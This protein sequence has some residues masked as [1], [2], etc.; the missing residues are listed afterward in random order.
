VG[1]GDWCLLCDLADKYGCLSWIGMVGL[2]GLVLCGCFLVML[3]GVWCLFWLSRTLL[4]LW[5]CCLF[6]LFVSL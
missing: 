3:F 4:A 1:V 5:R 2:A 6:V